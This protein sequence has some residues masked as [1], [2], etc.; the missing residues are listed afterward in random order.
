MFFDTIGSSDDTGSDE[1]PGGG[2]R[3]GGVHDSDSSQGGRPSTGAGGRD[4]RDNSGQSAPDYAALGWQVPGSPAHSTPPT[5]PPPPVDARHLP[6]QLVSGRE[7]K[8]QIA[9]P[10]QPRRRATPANPHLHH[11]T[12]RR[13]AMC[14]CAQPWWLGRRAVV[15]FRRWCRATGGGNDRNRNRPP[16]PGPRP[17]GGRGPRRACRADRAGRGHDDAN[18]TSDTGGGTGDT[19]VAD[20]AGVAG[21]VAIVPGQPPAH[22]HRAR[23]PL[24]QQRGDKNG[25]CVV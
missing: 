16:G 22:V 18:V 15:D 6:Q 9:R 13:A 21:V 25:G 8:V 11:T 7:K 5:Q 10:P 2:P 14:A 12:Q 1:D 24:A 3:N 23:V 20:V 17:T 4:G 19:D